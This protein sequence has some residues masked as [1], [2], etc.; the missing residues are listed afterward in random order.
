MNEN[1]LDAIANDENCP[2]FSYITLLSLLDHGVNKR[3]ALSSHKLRQRLLEPL[4][5]LKPFSNPSKL[6][7]NTHL[8]KSH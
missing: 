2:S 4:Q 6:F 5:L 3:T 1:H 7:I 8:A